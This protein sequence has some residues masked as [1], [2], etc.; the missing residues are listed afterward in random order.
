MRMDTR[1]LRV[2]TTTLVMEMFTGASPEEFRSHWGIQAACRRRGENNNR[3]LVKIVKIVKI[4]TIVNHRW[5]SCARTP[6][7]R[8]QWTSGTSTRT[9]W[10]WLSSA[11][12]PSSTTCPVKTF[13][14]WKL[15]AQWKL[16]KGE[17]FLPSE[18]FPK[19]NLLIV[20]IIYIIIDHSVE[21]TVLRL[22]GYGT[23]PLWTAP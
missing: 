22:V 18:N 10:R 21:A 5:T 11:Y 6:G 3:M 20:V 9:T 19:V 16:S 15:S 2:V 4:V 13:Q 14:R 12:P 7:R 17:N 23:A 1:M 8:S